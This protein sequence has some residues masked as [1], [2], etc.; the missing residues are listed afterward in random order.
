VVQ[1]ALLERQ[2]LLVLVLLLELELQ[3]VQEL[4]L[5]Q[6]PRRLPWCLLLQQSLRSTS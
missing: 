4:E 2:L 1:V 3:Q 6:E 5:V